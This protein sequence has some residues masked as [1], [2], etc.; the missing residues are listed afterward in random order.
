MATSAYSQTS[1]VFSWLLQSHGLTDFAERFAIIHSCRWD[2]H[3]R[4]RIWIWEAAKIKNKNG[5]KRTKKK[6]TLLKRL[7]SIIKGTK[8]KQENGRWSVHLGVRLWKGLWLHEHTET[9]PRLQVSS[10]VPITKR[11]WIR[12][13]WSWNPVADGKEIEWR[14]PTDSTSSGWGQS[15]DISR[16]L[17]PDNTHYFPGLALLHTH[18]TSATPAGC[19]MG[20][21]CGIACNEFVR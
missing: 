1:W 13:S 8:R 4:F 5:F 7:H 9:K 14:D 3:T 6:W 16:P 17:L 2:L 11:G 12:W 20:L 15:C 19:C 21:W 18:L 10:R